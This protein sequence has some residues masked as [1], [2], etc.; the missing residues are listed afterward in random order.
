MSPPP[1][2][3]APGSCAS[4]DDAAGPLFWVGISMGVVGSIGINV[5][6]N[7]QAAGIQSLALE[8]RH[9]PWRNVTWSLGTALFVSFSLINFAALAFAPASILTSLESI[10]FVTNVAYSKLINKA[11]IS[12]RMLIGVGCTSLGTILTVLFGA[13]GEGC[14]SL[15]N[16]EQ[17]WQ[18]VVWWIYLIA[19]LAVAIS[20]QLVYRWYSRRV[21]QGV[22]PANARFLR[23]IAFTT[24]AALGGGA[25]MIVHSKAFSELLAMCLQGDTSPLLSWLLYVEVGLVITCGMVWVV[26]LTECLALFPPLLILPLMVGTYILFGGIAGGI[27]FDEVNPALFFDALSGAPCL[28]ATYPPARSR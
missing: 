23:P 27:F 13:Q 10:Q 20:A 17:K 26:K 22:A 2:A 3:P 19:S 7:L 9:E 1:S 24:A 5:G 21:V 11:A 15:A 18:G 25:Q 16:L 14:K 6:Q 8:R 4:G 28:P 12:L